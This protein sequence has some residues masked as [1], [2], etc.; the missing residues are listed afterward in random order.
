MNIFVTLF[1]AIWFIV[2]WPFVKI[3]QPFVKLRVEYVMKSGARIVY[4]ADKIKVRKDTSNQEILEINVEGSVNWPTYVN[5]HEIAA[6]Q[7]R[8][9]SIFHRY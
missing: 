9:V 2:T 1:N 3:A 7:G 5:I 4:L 6:I 8:K